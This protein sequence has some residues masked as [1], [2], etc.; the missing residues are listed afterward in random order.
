MNIAPTQS[1]IVAAALLCWCTALGGLASVAAPAR[2]YAGFAS[3]PHST[4]PASPVDN[5][6][7]P[8]QWCPGQPLPMSD[9]VW[10]MNGCPT[11]YWVPVGGMGNVG[12][13]VWDGENPPPHAGPS[14]YGAPICLPGL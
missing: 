2:A 8:H 1:R 4:A 6:S 7:V 3:P 10:D 9:V 5:F 11:W 14:C 13:F 12:Q